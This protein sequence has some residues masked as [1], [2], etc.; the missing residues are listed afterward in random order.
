MPVP[1]I[2][3]APAA[4]R[5][6][7]DSAQFAL[8]AEAFVAWMEGA[9]A[10]FNE[11]ADY[12]AALG[13]GTLDPTLALIAE[14]PTSEFGRALLT[15]ADAAALRG[16]AELGSAATL[17]VVTLTQADYD[18]MPAKNASTLYLIPEA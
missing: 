7:E 3:P 16:A 18:A 14:L 10:E 5:R 13:S 15:L 6:S 9:P 11:L 12:L 4:P 1:T 2:T 17:N 8:K